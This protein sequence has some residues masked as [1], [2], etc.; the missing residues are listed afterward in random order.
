MLKYFKEK[1]SKTQVYINNSIYVV[2]ANPIMAN[3]P[4]V[5]DY[6]RAKFDDLRK[7]L[8]DMDICSLMR[9]NVTETSIDDDWSI[10]KNTVM[11]AVHN[12]IPTKSK[13]VDLH[14]SP[15]WITPTILHQIRKKATA[16]KKFLHK[17]TEYL[18]EKFS[19]LRSEVKKVIQ[20][21]RESFF[22]SLGSFLKV[23]PNR[24]LSVFKFNSK[25]WK[26][27]EPCLKIRQ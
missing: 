20:E 3:R 18:K 22:A 5:Y 19:K 17:G 27:T 9:N 15:P 2:Y 23:N 24:F 16:R 4:F 6:G 26:H 14:R 12:C 10:W 11:T 7:R 1:T 25:F 13:Y 21:S 8:T